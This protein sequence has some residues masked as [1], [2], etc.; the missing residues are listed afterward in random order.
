MKKQDETQSQFDEPVGIVIS[1]GWE[2]ET[3]PRFSAYMWAPGP[4]DETEMD[5]QPV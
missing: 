3:T 4:E 1:R 2:P 5:A